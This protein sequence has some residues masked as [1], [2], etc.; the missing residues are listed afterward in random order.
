MFS[1]WGPLSTRQLPQPR[2]R[3]RFKNDGVWT[4]E[5]CLGSRNYICEIRPATSARTTR[6]RSNSAFA[7]AAFRTSTPTATAS[8]T[9]KNGV[10]MT[11][12]S[13]SRATGLLLTPQGGRHPCRD[14]LCAANTQCNGA[15]VCGDPRFVRR[16]TPTATRAVARN[17]YYWF[18]GNDRHFRRRK[19]CAANPWAPTSLQVND[20]FEDKSSPQNTVEFTSLGATD[21]AVEGDWV[22]L[23]KPMP[24][25]TGGLLGSPVA[26]AYSNWIFGEPSDGPIPRDCLGKDSVAPRRLLAGRFSWNDRRSPSPASA[27]PCRLYPSRST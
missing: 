24:F 12:R 20:A 19:A 23:G 27:N 6:R 5:G 1:N 15:G 10:R 3:S 25:W 22:W 11:R 18:C 8:S 26:G 14:G 17:T 7:A 9:A 2:L 4:D 21:Q 16:P 13:S